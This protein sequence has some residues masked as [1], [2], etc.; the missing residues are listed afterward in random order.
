MNTLPVVVIGAGPIGL[1]AAALLLTRG[2]TLIVFEAGSG[3]G[4]AIRESGH[5]RLLSPWRYL[6]DRAATALL[7]QNG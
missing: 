5:V 6:V 4:A 1:A 3:V 2:E 7:E